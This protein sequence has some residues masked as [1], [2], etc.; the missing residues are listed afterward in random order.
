M[1]SIKKKIAS[2]SRCE[3]NTA[4]K[5]RKLET[6][7]LQDTGFL[8]GLWHLKYP[9]LWLSIPDKYKFARVRFHPF[10]CQSEKWGDLG[11]VDLSAHTGTRSLMVAPF[12]YVLDPN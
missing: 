11:L 5:E 2:V 7:Y 9:K 12:F 6:R 10:H 8:E 1:T 3:Y 4:R